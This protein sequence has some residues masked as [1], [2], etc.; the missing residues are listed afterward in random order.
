MQKLELIHSDVCGPMEEENWGE[1]RFMLTL[2][3][4]FTR[5]TFVYTVWK[6]SDIKER[7]KK[8][9]SMVENQTGKR[10]EV[11]RTDDGTEYVN[12]DLQDYLKNVI[13]C[14][15]GQLPAHQRS[16]EWQKGQTE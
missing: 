8:F 2:I 13:S 1:G 16:M 9:K 7:F 3:H 10:I 6:K 15:K 4:D 5:N 11:L 14:I 12:T